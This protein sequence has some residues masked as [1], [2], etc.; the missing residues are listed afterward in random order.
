[1]SVASVSILGITTNGILLKT[2]GVGRLFNLSL[3]IEYTSSLSYR[4]KFLQCMELPLTG[5]SSLWS[6]LEAPVFQRNLTTYYWYNLLSATLLTHLEAGHRHPTSFY[7]LSGIFWRD[8]LS[9]EHSF[10]SLLFFSPLTVKRFQLNNIDG[11][12]CCLSNKSHFL[13]KSSR[14]SCQGPSLSSVFPKKWLPRSWRHRAFLRFV[15]WNPYS[16]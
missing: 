7:T 5:S 4:C 11:D 3:T 10:F 16:M 6:I 8:A 13:L 1:M 15:I 12:I 14:Y 9:L 2:A